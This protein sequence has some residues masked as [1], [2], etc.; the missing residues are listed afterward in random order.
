MIYFDGGECGLE[1]GQG[2]ERGGGGRLDGRGRVG[3]PG[4][5]LL[6]EGDEGGGLEGPMGGE[7]NLFQLLDGFPKAPEGGFRH[8]SS[9]VSAPQNASAEMRGRSLI[10]WRMGTHVKLARRSSAA[11]WAR[12]PRDSSLGRVPFWRFDFNG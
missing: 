1:V 3:W 2:E 11:I 9:Q 8:E 4:G 6:K 12:M 7:G 5:R 10:I